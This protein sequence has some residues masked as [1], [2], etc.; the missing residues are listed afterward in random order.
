MNPIEKYPQVVND[1][2][3]FATFEPSKKVG[4]SGISADG[5]LINRFCTSE[6]K[7]SFQDFLKSLSF[8]STL[9]VNRNVTA[10][11]VHRLVTSYPGRHPQTH[12]TGSSRVES[13]KITQPE[14]GGFFVTYPFLHIP[15][16]SG[17]SAICLS[18]GFE[19]G[20]H[21]GKPYK[22]TNVFGFFPNNEE[23]KNVLDLLNKAFTKRILF[24][25][26]PSAITGNDIVKIAGGITLKTSTTPNVER[27]DCYPDKQYLPDLKE[28]LAALGIE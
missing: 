14:D 12:A 3:A 25:I 2:A 10:L 18:I 4:L 8:D 27:A 13:T 7:A 22:G 1:L 9:L 24:E 23:G 11:D 26:S 16:F 21:E 19:D 15:G 20:V 5:R 28:K 17:K 6:E